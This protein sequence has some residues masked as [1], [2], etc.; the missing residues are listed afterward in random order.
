MSK[1]IKSNILI[2]CEIV[3]GI[4]ENIRKCTTAKMGRKEKRGYD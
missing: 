3:K 4:Q 1:A 2:A